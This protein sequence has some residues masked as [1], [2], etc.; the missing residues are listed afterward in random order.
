MVAQYLLY[1]HTCMQTVRSMLTECIHACMPADSQE[2]ADRIASAV[3]VTHTSLGPPILT[4]EQAIQNK[5]FFTS[6]P[7]V[8]KKVGDTEGVATHADTVYKCRNSGEIFVGLHFRYQAL[9]AFFRG[10]IFVVCGAEHVIIVAYIF[11]G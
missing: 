4:L 8:V 9:K 5:S 2:H 11:V 1:M 7:R 10:L 6:P 3:V